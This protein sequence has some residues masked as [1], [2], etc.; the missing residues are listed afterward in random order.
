MSEVGVNRLE[1]RINSVIDLHRNDD[2]VS[3]AEIIGLLEI[4]KQDMYRELFDDEDDY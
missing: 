4:I 3:I 1:N 2:S